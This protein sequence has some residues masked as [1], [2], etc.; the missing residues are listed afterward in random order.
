MSELLVPKQEA[1][2]LNRPTDA[3]PMQLIERALASGASLEMM[4]KLLDL[5][6]KYEADEARKAFFESFAAF[7]AEKF[8]VVRDKE[9]TQYS[10]PGK[11]AMYS[12]L[13]GMV[14]T[15]TPFMAKHG[16]S[17]AWEIDQSAGITVTCVITHTLGH[18]KRVPMTG[19]LDTSGAKNPLQQIKSTVTYLK[20]A[21][22][23]SAL[24]I[25]SEYGSLSDD[26]NGSAPRPNTM[27]LD[28]FD[29]YKQLIEAAST[30]VDLK[31]YF[32]SGYT[33]AQRI[34]DKVAMANF[35]KARDKRKAELKGEAA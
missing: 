34:G 1:L 4:D 25:A 28:E 17:H 14:A 21:T 8:T 11:P 16:L 35:I 9:N 31:K 27:E 23:E 5:K 26:G 7:K 15:V 13:E 10:K 22:F 20:T 32:N 29:S 24:G 30:E 3:S 2:T 18:S 19:G 12:S 33:D 6:I